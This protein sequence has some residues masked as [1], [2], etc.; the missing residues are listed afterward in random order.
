MRL[1]TKS[2][3]AVTALL[4][5]ALHSVERPVALTVVSQR[6]HISLAYLEQLFARLRKQGL[7]ESV[8]GPGGGYRLSKAPSE[9]SVSRVIRAVD[10]EIDATQCGGQRN[11]HGKQRCMTHDLWTALNQNIID[12]LSGISLADVLSQQNTAMPQQVAFQ[13]SIHEGLGHE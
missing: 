9:I 3:F 7:V 8:R 6:Q 12:Y 4:D 5:L 11:C 13:A 1:T 10:E 2:R